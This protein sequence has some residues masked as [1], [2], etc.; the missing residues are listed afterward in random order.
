MVLNECGEIVQT[1]WL[2]SAEIRREI[3]LDLF[4]V[5][6]NHFHGNVF[7]RGDGDAPKGDRPKA[8]PSTPPT[9]SIPATPIPPE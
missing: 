9:P 5:M 8:V 7:L 6:P 4:V 1:Q 3:E 2:Q